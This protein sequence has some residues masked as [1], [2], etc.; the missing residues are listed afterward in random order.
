[1]TP[2]IPVP[3]VISTTPVSKEG[4]ETEGTIDGE[5]KGV[6]TKDQEIE[7]DLKKPVQVTEDPES[8]KEEEKPTDKQLRL[9]MEQKRLEGKFGKLDQVQEDES[10]KVEPGKIS[11]TLDLSSQGKL[12]EF[13]TCIEACCVSIFKAIFKSMSHIKVG[14]FILEKTLAKLKDLEKIYKT[15]IEKLTGTYNSF[16]GWRT[17]T[18]LKS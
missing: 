9:A 10:E 11:T 15:D 13:T 1:M 5:K 4:T 12:K 14:F 8:E 6:V 7:E 16:K 3:Q 18:L 2:P 17:L